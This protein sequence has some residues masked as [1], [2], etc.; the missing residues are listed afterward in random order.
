[1]KGHPYLLIVFKKSI[2]IGNVTPISLLRY[3]QV[4]HVDEEIK[5]IGKIFVPRVYRN[6][7]P[8]KSSVILVSKKDEKKG[9]TLIIGDSM[10]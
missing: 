4:P 10:R 6:P 5:K 2:Y 9:C 1:M 3:R 8:H 7:R